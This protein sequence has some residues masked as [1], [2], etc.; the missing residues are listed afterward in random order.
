MSRS[1]NPPPPWGLVLVRLVTGGVLAARGWRWVRDGG[2][3]G[4]AIDAYVRAAL[5]DAGGLARWWAELFL[6]ENPEGVALL[7]R[8]AAL[9]LGALLFAGALTRPAGAL[10]SFFLLH[11]WLY[12]PPQAALALF[13]LLVGAVACSASRAGRRL[14]LDP[15]LD[16][17]LPAWLTWTRKKST[18]L[19]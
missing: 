5:P 7:A 4:T 3:D 6:L 15:L 1:R 17:Q 11:A 8:S 13:L 16:D 9:V 14:G 19:S 2:M 18:F 10:A 12:A